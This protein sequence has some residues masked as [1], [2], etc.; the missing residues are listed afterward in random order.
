[1]KTSPA[2]TGASCRTLTAEDW[3]AVKAI[4]EEG[5]ASGDATF[6]QT[7]PPWPDWDAAHLSG[8][9]LVAIGG[10]GRVVGWAALTRVSSRCV[11]AGVAEVSVYVASSARG[12]GVGTQLLTALV[13]RSETHG[14]WTLQAGVFPE[15]VASVALHERC[16]FR[17]VGRRERLGQMDGRWRDVLLLERRS[18][19]V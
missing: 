15:N 1:V 17:V 3:P 12:R 10:D 9:R 19:R 13:E 16:G 8:C 18:A 2:T 4:Y 7:A 14:L 11:Y 6:E 5:I